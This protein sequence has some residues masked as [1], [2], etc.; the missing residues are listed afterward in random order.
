M[1]Q[2][3]KSEFFN[4]E[5][6]RVLHAAPF[7]G[8]EIG[9]CLVAR[10]R[11]TDNDPESWYRAWTAEAERA[12]SV[13]ED[14]VKHGDRVEAS[15]AF[16]RASNYY[17]SSEFF[18]HCEPQD[19]RLLNAAQKSFDI[20]ERGVRLLDG[21][22]H[23][24]EIPFEGNIS[25]PAR[26]F[27]PPAHKM[28]TDK[29]PILVQM[30]GF[31]STQEEL[32]FYGPA[33]GLPRGY[34]V[35]TFDGPGQGISL[36]R[37]RTHM[38]SDW[39][40]VTSKVLDFLESKLAANHNI[41]M[42]RVAVLGASLGGY[43]V[44][45]AAADPRVRAA[46]S[47]D[48]CYDLFDVTK[49]RMPNW[50][51]GGWLNGWLSDSFFNFVVNRLAAANF[52]LR[53]EFGHSMWI[54]GVNNPADVMRQMQR[55][56]LRLEDGGEYL[57]KLKCATMITGASD[58]FYFVPEINAERI[59]RKLDHID[60]SKKELWIGKG[61]S[62]GGLQAK[63][64]ALALSHQRM[65]AF[66]D[67]QFGITRP[68]YQILAAA[69][70]N[71]INVATASDYKHMVTNKTP[72]FLAKFPIGK[73][74]AFEATDGTTIAESDAIAQYVSEV[75][76]RSVQLLGAN[77][78]ERARVRQWISF[79]DNE[80]YGNMMGVVLSRA[81]FAPYVPEK[82]AAAAK[83]LSFGLG[84]V[85]KWLSGREWL[86]TDQ[87]SLA[88]LTLAAALYWAYMHYLDDKRREA[89]PLVTSWYLRTIGAEGVKD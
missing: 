38:V 56:T 80:V 19:P 51:I 40:R 12:V 9:E 21:E 23:T 82:E 5:F 14:A 48:G 1:F 33:G 45:R 64:G 22:L 44:L 71:G 37:D 34:A 13:G 18:L 77:A 67:M 17:R 79:T 31:D 86:A 30:G 53:W 43:L 47:T 26:L 75:G 36:R 41:D 39:E 32:Y 25:M 10:T 88:D 52:Q 87:L 62:E 6:L 61:V 7:H 35:L 27:L 2:F 76:P 63:I 65:F 50:F 59:F 57:S 66:L 78:P 70:V 46:I 73:V 15:W 4:F 58:T 8:S 68:A 60:N 85:E 69:K 89:Y 3:F 84:V 81:G 11:I 54:Y 28:V 29:L 16:I 20:F 72:E 49:S 24:L 55:F 83:G 74:P 42:D